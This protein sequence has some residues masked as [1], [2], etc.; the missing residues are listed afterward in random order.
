[1]L[2]SRAGFDLAIDCAGV[3]A[4][5]GTALRSVRRGGRVVMTALYGSRVLLSV[6]RVVNGEVVLMGSF[7]YRDE[8]HRVIELI[9]AGRLDARAMITHEF[10]LETAQEAFDTQLRA[11]E[12]IKVVLRVDPDDAGIEEPAR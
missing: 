10:D 12:S 8:L 5:I 9:A 7:A 2:A 6:D 4:S 11:D 3:E 1:M